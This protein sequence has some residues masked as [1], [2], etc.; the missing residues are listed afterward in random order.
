MQMEGLAQRIWELARDLCPSEPL[1]EER[2]AARGVCAFAADGNH[3]NPSECCEP[4][5]HLYYKVHP[6]GTGALKK[7]ALNPSGR[8]GA[9]GKPSFIWSPHLTGMG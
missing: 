2:R 1:G 7:T 8:H 5:F 3:P 4:G 6:D 9:D